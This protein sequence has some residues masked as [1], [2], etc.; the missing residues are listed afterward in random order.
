MKA[1]NEAS[2]VEH[3]GKADR[4]GSD[5]RSEGASGDEAYIRRKSLCEAR[6][7]LT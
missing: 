6:L 2:P 3:F 4:A 1:E 5:C 7:L